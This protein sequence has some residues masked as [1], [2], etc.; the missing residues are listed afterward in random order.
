MSI[1]QSGDH[2]LH[3]EEINL[4]GPW[5]ESPAT[6]LFNHGLGSVNESWTQWLPQLIDRYRILRFDLRG[7]GKSSRG[8]LE[9]LSLENLCADALAVADAAGVEQF[10]FVGESI[11]GTVGLSLAI[12]QQRRLLSLTASNCVYHGGSIQSTEPFESLLDE[13]GTPAWS[14]HMMPLRFFEDALSP[15]KHSWY[16]QQQSQVSPELLLKSVNLLAA[17]DLGPALD[18]I[19]CPVLLLQ[20]DA[21]PFVSVESMAGL[22]ER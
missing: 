11:G 15:D 1:V 13:G 20:A 16:E 21:S 17:T 3:Y 8:E 5:I 22:E 7:H 2:Q 9:N 10:H 19:R 4:V 18:R 12:E 14:R 6:I